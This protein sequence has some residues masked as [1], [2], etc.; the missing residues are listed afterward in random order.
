MEERS[1][2]ILGPYFLKG[3]VLEQFQQATI[4]KPIKKLCAEETES[5]R[6]ICFSPKDD[7]SLGSVSKQEIL[8]ASRS[9]GIWDKHNVKSL[10]DVLSHF[11]KHPMKK[12]VV[13]AARRRAFY[14]QFPDS[15][16]SVP[17]GNLLYGEGD[18]KGVYPI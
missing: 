3:V 13:D 14:H 8:Q 1:E 11:A 12:L 17:E 4:D 7:A 9:A 18:P 16:S 15:G 2:S 6:G 5:S 10:Y